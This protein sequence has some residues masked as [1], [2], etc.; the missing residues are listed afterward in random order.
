MTKYT[1]II[2]DRR[3]HF[4]DRA[5]FDEKVLSY[6]DG[7]T[8]SLELKVVRNMRSLK[9]NGYYFFLV[10]LLSDHTGFTKDEMH[11]ILKVSCLSKNVSFNGK[12]IT[13]A[14]SSTD[15]NTKEFE[16]YMILVR[17]IGTELKVFMPLPNESKFD[18]TIYKK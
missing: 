16:E 15:L 10:K 11:E 8:L 18:Y 14:G 9:Q 3:I 17:E 12:D 2:K 13:I 4:H 7:T 1:A 5:S 6:K